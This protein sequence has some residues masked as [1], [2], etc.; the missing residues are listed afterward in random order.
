MHEISREVIREA[1]QNG[2]EQLFLTDPLLFSR[3]LLEKRIAQY[4][5]AEKQLETHIF[6]DRGIPDVTAYL[7]Y[8]GNSYPENFIEANTVHRYD[9]IFILPVWKEIHNT[10]TERYESY[11]QSLKIQEYLVETYQNLNYDLI[12]VPKMSIEERAKFI[13]E[14][15]GLST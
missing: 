8:I 2:I 12:S 15:L 5:E 1:Q 4:Q 13:L 11:E 14:K 6:I 7:D 10:D 3:L 9:K